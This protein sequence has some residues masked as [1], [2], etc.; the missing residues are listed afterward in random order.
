MASFTSF[1]VAVL[2]ALWLRSLDYGWFAA[3]G[4]A[5]AVW[6]ILPFVISQ[7]CAAFVLARTHR[8]IQGA[9]NLASKIAKAT[10]GLPPDEALAVGKRIIDESFK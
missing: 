4:S 3:L 9:D 6:I 7:I 1:G 5:I 10:K 2:L 8:H